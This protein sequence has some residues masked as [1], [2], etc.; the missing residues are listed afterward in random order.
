M[1]EEQNRTPLIAE[2]LRAFTLVF[3][4]AILVMSIVVMLVI[5]YAPDPQNMSSLFS[6]GTGLSFGSILQIAG[7]SLVLAVFSVLFISERFFPA[8]RFLYRILFFFLSALLSTSLFAAI[9]GWIPADNPLSWIVFISFFIV[10]YTVSIGLT[11]LWLRREKKKYGRLLAE[12]KAL[13]TD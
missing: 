7:M 6:L 10:C 12:Y 5:R 2:F 1:N 9:F 11:L 3:T 13:H 4:P 8:T